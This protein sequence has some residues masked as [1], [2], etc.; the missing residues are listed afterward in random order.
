MRESRQEPQAIVSKMFYRMTYGV[1]K[2]RW[3]RFREAI[4]LWIVTKFGI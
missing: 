3:Q 1:P 4:K 2:T